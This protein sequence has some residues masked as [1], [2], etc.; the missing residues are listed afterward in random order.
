MYPV[1]RLA[2]TVVSALRADRIDVL[3]T[4]T[5]TL[6]VKRGDVEA[7]R[8][9]NGRYLTLMDLGR[10]ALTLRG[11]YLPILA[12]RRWYPLVSSVMIRFWRSLGVGTTFELSTRI[13][14]WDRRCFFLEQWFEQGGDLRARALV[15]AL[16]MG[17]DGP[18]GTAEFL[19]AGGF[20]T[21]SPPFPE[22][23]TVWQAA[24]A[25]ALPR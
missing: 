11:G 8:M 16:F 14:C 20:R 10:F 7:T 22:S 9:N 6:P 3:D 21:D 25:A 12:K 4:A 23:V 19:R 17:P 2:T 24:E 1:I 15:K 13:V 5:I 18:L